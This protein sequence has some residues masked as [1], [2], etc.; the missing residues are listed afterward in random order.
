MLTGF[1][2][3]FVGA[4]GFAILIS[5]F[6]ESWFVETGPRIV[7]YA[8]QVAAGP[9]FVLLA[10]GIGQRI[11]VDG[12]S[13]LMWIVAGALTFDGLFIG[14]WPAI[15]GQEGFALTMT[16]SMLLWAFAWIVIAGLIMNRDRR[17]T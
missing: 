9:L 16:A 7:L 13:V 15:Y 5:F 8:A 3:G 12:Q 4:L 10:R 14:F 17:T 11:G 6:P 2:V 1:I